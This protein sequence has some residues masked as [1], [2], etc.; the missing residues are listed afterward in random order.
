MLH[1][2][3][4]KRTLAVGYPNFAYEG[5]GGNAV[6]RNVVGDRVFTAN[7]SP[8]DRRIPFHHEL[9][10]SPTY[11]HRVLFFCDVPAAVGG[12]TPLLDSNRVYVK[13]RE[14]VPR[15]VDELERK[16]VRYTR[17][18]TM[19]D[20]PSSAIGRGWRGT[21]G[22]GDASR[23]RFTMCFNLSLPNHFSSRQV[24]SRAA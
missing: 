5:A 18:M 23:A 19:D 24:R 9:A 8:P 12:A 7:E 17:I 13:L 10:Q 16:G 6:R 15:F 2:R 22:G 14:L 3:E 4:V 11:P 21:F 1:S 20:R